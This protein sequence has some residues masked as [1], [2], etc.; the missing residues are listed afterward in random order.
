[1][2]SNR[3]I[4]KEV[5]AI[6]ADRK[7]GIYKGMFNLKMVDTDMYH[8]TATLYAPAGTPYEGYEFD[9]DVKIP[10][11]YPFSA[12]HIK[13][14]TPIQHINI[15]TDGD[16][17]LDILKDKWTGSMNVQSL[18]VSIS[19]LIDAPNYADEFNFD[20]A[21]IYKTDKEKYLNIIKE[22]CKKHARLNSSST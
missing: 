4:V 11:E 14:I 12:P 17:C 2:A 15:N 16:I 3:R 19:S 21:S 6:E 8:W 18:L 7:S 5:K 13:F 20:L 10:P 22:G 1:M 9:L